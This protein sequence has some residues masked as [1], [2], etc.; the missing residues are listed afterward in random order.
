MPRVLRIAVSFA[1]VLVAYWAYALVAVPL[2]EPQADP[3]RAERISA[4]DEEVAVA[5][6]DVFFQLQRE[7]GYLPC[8]VWADRVGTGQIQMVV[9]IAATYPL[10]TAMLSVLILGE[11]LTPLRVIGTVLIIVGIWFV[12]G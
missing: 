9:P 2:I 10:V 5:N 7:G 11:H 12:Q 4:V 8:W 6:H 3:H 1:I